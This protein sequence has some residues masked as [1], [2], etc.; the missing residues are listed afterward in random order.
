MKIET[1]ENVKDQIG[2]CGIWCGSCVVGNGV[3][4]E[5]TKRYGEIIKKYGV[6]EWGPKDFD[7]KEFMNGLA[8]IQTI[9]VCQ[10]CLK[11]GGRTNCEMRNCA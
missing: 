5:L 11:D 10:G 8:S 4:R 1:F 3:L 9:P 7:V 6:D 2:F